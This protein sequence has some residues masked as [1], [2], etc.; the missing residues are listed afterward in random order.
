VVTKNYGGGQ[1]NPLHLQLLGHETTAGWIPSTRLP[2]ARHDHPLDRACSE[3]SLDSLKQYCNNPENSVFVRHRLKQ[4][5][6]VTIKDLRELLSHATPIADKVITLYLELLTTQYN[7]SFL[8]TNTIPQM[9]SAGWTRVQRCFAQFRNRQ[10]SNT[11][12]ALHG[13]PV[14]IIPC[15]V[16][17]CHWVVVVHRE[18][19]GEVIFLFADDLNSIQTE[20]EVKQL[21]SATNTSQDFYPPR[22]RWIS[23]WN[24]TYMPQ[25]NECGPRSMVAATIMAL[26]PNP[27]PS[28]LLP[29]MHSNL[30]QIAR[31]WV[32]NS[33]L[34]LTKKRRVC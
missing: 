26:H 21:L 17:G 11:R 29:Y 7:F 14:I 24:Y 13:E 20:N 23:C 16:H 34:W 28:I 10:C 32:A 22:S 12:P 25:S 30:A 5:V 31:T 4:D 8:P 27:M 2:H 33:T 15:F 18:I 1:P 3:Q 19:N 6:H 9:R